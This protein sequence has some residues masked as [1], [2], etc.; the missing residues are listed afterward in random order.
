M[1]KNILIL[2]CISCLYPVVGCKT[3]KKYIN[4]V[5]AEKIIEIDPNENRDKVLYSE[6]FDSLKY[7]CLETTDNILIKSITRLKYVNNKIYILD[8]R[9]QTVFCFH[10]D[11]ELHWKIHSVGQGP[12]EYIQLAGFDIDNENNKLYLFS[13]RDKIQVYDLSGNF[14]EEYNVKLSGTS[15]ASHKDWMYIYGNTTSNEIDGITDGNNYLYLLNKTR[16]KQKGELPFKTDKRFGIMNIYNS[17]NAFCNYNDEIRFFMPFSNN[18]YSIKE[19]NVYI[20]YHFDFGEYN[21]PDDYF[22]NY[23]TD[24]LYES[25]YAYGLNSFWEN[26]KYYS[27]HVSVNQQPCEVLYLKK[28]EK[29]YMR[30]LYDDMAYCSPAISESTNDYILGSRMAEDLITEY[31]YS[32]DVRKNTVLEKIITEITED[33]NPVIFFYYFKK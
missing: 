21:L 29:I 17:P 13:R 28:E 2:I 18:I 30:G 4:D 31:N 8:E 22:D 19:D 26:D 33:D 7:I 5:S 12:E 10:M 15:F 1:R 3:D 9:T 24:N 20:K 16:K 25:K 11:G 32:E 23:T 6:L 14:V 27:F